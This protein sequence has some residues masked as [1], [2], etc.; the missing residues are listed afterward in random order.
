MQAYFGSAKFGEGRFWYKILSTM[1]KCGTN[2]PNDGR[3][4]NGTGDFHFI[5]AAF[6]QLSYLLSLQVTSETAFKSENMM[7]P[8][9]QTREPCNGKKMCIDLVKARTW[10]RSLKTT[11]KC[12]T[13]LLC[14]ISPFRISHLPTPPPHPP[15]ELWAMSRVHWR[16]TAQSAE[17]K[18]ARQWPIRP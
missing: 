5:I 7:S 18:W 17:R 14:H 16:Q 1:E 3:C 11:S 6:L 13:I 4:R 9:I 10:L 8:T 2:F 15:K 12:G